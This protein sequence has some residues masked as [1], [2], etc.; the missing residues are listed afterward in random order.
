M[1]ISDS[2]Y[3][4]KPNSERYWIKK[5]GLIYIVLWHD[6]ED[7]IEHEIEDSRWEDRDKAVQ[8]CRILN[9][10]DSDNEVRNG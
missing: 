10:E 3:F 8:H 9:S 4:E 2:L 5:H 7:W 1:T 6:M